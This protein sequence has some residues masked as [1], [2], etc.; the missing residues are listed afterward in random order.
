MFYAD[1]AQAYHCKGSVENSYL[2]LCFNQR[3]EP[4]A[5]LFMNRLHR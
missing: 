2:K 3:A 5:Q 4:M 1:V